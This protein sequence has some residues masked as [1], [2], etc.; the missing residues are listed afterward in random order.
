MSQVIVQL[1]MPETCS[2]KHVNE[3]A[4][5]LKEQLPILNPACKKAV[6][7]LRQHSRSPEFGERRFILVLQVAKGY[8]IRHNFVCQVQ[9]IHPT[10]LQTDKP[11][12]CS[13]M[14]S[15][16]L[17]TADISLSETS[18]PASIASLDLERQWS[19]PKLI[20]KLVVLDGI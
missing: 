16:S 2:V 3:I 8:S 11:K 20:N 4:S 14:L 12:R 15:E 6:R 7:W 1:K 9:W 10:V 17:A 13:S 5:C 19:E 18:Q